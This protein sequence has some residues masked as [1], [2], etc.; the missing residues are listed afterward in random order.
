[1]RKPADTDHPVHDLIRE[2]WSPRALSPQPVER[3]KVQSLFEAARWAPSA[4]NEQPWAFV[5]AAKEDGEAWTKLADCL[6]EGNAWAREAPLLLLTLASRAFSHNGKPN[7]YA[8]HDVGLATLSLI[9]QAESMG[10]RAHA[11]A[12]Y[13]GEKARTDL[14]IPESHEPVA[15]VAIGYPGDARRLPERVR[16]LEAKPRTRHPL[17]QFVFSGRFGA[18][19]PGAEA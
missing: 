18:T 13:D 14:A 4:F 3:E 8:R 11:M 10:L 12:G 9:L 2:R 1:M 17:A 15:M 19:W 5:V 6:V 7:A 16:G